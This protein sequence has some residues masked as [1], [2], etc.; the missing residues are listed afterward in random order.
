MSSNIWGPPI[1]KFFH[2]LVAAI[3]E[4]H[5]HIIGPPIFAIIKQICKNLPCP[6]CS[7]HATN[8]LSAVR[9]QYIQ[10]KHDMILLIYTF[11]NA[12]NKRKGRPLFHESGLSVYNNVNLFQAFNQFVNAYKTRG[13]M[14]L[15][16]DS[17]A[18]DITVKQVKQF[19]LKNRA[20]LNINVAS[21]QI[22]N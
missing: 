4:N 2:S 10:N 15:M 18:R 6:V 17:F 11:H 1:W 19:L 8:F 7:L 21:P 12:V 3:K 22:T 5:F 16:A 14:K 20:H 9:F 13:N